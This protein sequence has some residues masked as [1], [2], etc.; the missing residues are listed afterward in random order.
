MYI[1][2][3]KTILVILLF[4]GLMFI[5]I[6]IVK[7]MNKCEPSKIIYKYIPRTFEDEQN[8]PVMVSDIF[9]VMFSQPSPWVNTLKSYDEEKRDKINNFFI[10][11]A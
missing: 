6:D 7:S 5:I 3:D 1:M 8:N 11:Q 2:K 4:I 10:S 9:K